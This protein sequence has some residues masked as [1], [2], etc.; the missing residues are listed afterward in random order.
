[1]KQKKY[2]CMPKFLSNNKTTYTLRTCDE[3]VREN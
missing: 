3:L 2:V 1:M